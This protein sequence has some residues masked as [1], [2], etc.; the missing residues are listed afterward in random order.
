MDASRSTPVKAITPVPF[1]LQTLQGRVEDFADLGCL[2]RDT[3]GRAS[4]DCGGRA[5]ST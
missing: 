5:P 1:D 4:D 2:H 3:D